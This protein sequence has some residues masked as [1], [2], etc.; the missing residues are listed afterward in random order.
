MVWLVWIPLRKRLNC[1]KLF[2][3]K[4]VTYSLSGIPMI[5]LYF[6]TFFQKSNILRPCTPYWCRSVHRD[7]WHRME[8]Q[9]GSLPTHHC[10]LSSSH[11]CHETSTGLRH[12]QNIWCS[13]IVLPCYHHGEGPFTSVGV[14]SGLGW[15][16]LCPNSSKLF[17][18]SGNRAPI[19]LW[20]THLPLLLPQ[21]NCH[22]ALWFF[23]I[24]QKTSTLVWSTFIWLIPTEAST[25]LSSL[26]KRSSHQAPD[27]PCLEVCG[28]HLLAQ[29]LNH[30]KEVFHLS[31]GDIYAWTD[32]T[33][34]LNWLSGNQRRFKMYVDN[35]VCSII[36]H[37]RQMESHVS[38]TENPAECAS[39]GLLPFELLEH[40]LLWKGPPWF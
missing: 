29:L 28:A 30:I 35:R 25:S 34:I 7:T 31:L 6:S 11:K 37:I 33:A 12:C 15:M 2:S 19:S 26:P 20:K 4:M 22:S 23:Q 9:I 14:E 27:I 24:H 36:E 18:C 16:I 38:G 3:L 21:R 1:T 17:G 5:L 13:G 32:S 8:C 40:E 39:R 10:W